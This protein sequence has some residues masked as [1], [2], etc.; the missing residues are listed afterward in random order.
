MDLN[1]KVRNL[2]ESSVKEAGYILDE[3]K[4]VTEDGQKVLMVVIDKEDGVITLDDCVKV[5]EIVNPMIEE[6]DLIEENYVLDICSK[7]KG[8]N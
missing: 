8:C 3:I 1:E 6:A 4:Y 5:T 7:E 2:V